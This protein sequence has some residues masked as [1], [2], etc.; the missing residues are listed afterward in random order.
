MPSTVMQCAEMERMCESAGVK[1]VHGRAVFAALFRHGEQDLRR[2]RGL[3]RPFYDWLDAHTELPQ[4]RLCARNISA[5][6]ASKY[7]LAM[8]DGGTVE[9]VMIPCG[10]RLSQCIS[11]QI[12]CAAGCAFCLTAAGGFVRNLSAGEM[13]AQVMTGWRLYGRRARNLVLMGMGE[14]LHNYEET[15]RFVRIATD[16]LGLSFSPRRVTVS[17]AGYVPGIRRLIE[18][19]LPCNL[20]LSLNATLDAQR[21]RIMPIGR[22]WPL[23]ELLHWAG[24]FARRTKKRLLIEYVLLAGINDTD[25]DARRLLELLEP[26]PCTINL[27]PFNEFPGSPFHRPDAARVHAFRNLLAKAGRVVVV[28]RSRGLD[29]SAACGQLRSKA[30]TG[31]WPAAFLSLETA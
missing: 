28:R 13:V 21:R 11:T 30:A 25:A 6:G 3:P 19:R 20:A 1:A 14:P 10:N 12:G 27:L 23:A 24:V 4:P 17:T 31:R 26:I 18:D 9:T 22:R 5:D 2:I 29:I 16:P 7:V 8:D 15:A